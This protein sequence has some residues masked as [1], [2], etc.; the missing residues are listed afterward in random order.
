MKFMHLND[1]SQ[2]IPKGQPGH[3]PLYKLRPFFDPLI[4]NF[5]ETYT[6]AREMSVDEQMIGFKG[7][8]WWIQYAKPE[9]FE[10][11]LPRAEYSRDYAQRL[12]L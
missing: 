10:E 8:L 4:A 6:P 11:Y 5:K 12:T 1:N 9:V 2:Y 3:N 7:R